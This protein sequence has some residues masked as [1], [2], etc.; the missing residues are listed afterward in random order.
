MADN[1]HNQTAKIQTAI[2]TRRSAMQAGSA[3]ALAAGAPLLWPAAAWADKA[4]I[5]TVLSKG[6]SS[7][8]VPGVVAI[9]AD[10]KGVIYEGAFGKRDLGTARPMTLDTVFWIASMT[11]AV[12]STAAMQLVEQGKLSLDQP[13]SRRRCRSSASPQVLEGF[14]ADGRAASCGRP[15]GRSRCATC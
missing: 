10:D 8:D 5:D 7:G 12:T 1:K 11:K 4:K 3:A 9:A 13:I 2:I 6:V 14:D 15:S